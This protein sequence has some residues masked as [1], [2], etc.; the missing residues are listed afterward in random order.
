MVS[1]QSN[2]EMKGKTMGLLLPDR[3][4]FDEGVF[5][6]YQYDTMLRCELQG[7]LMLNSKSFEDGG[8]I[9]IPI[10]YK[11]I[12]SYRNGVA[13][14]INIAGNLIYIR[15]DGEKLY[16]Q[17]FPFIPELCEDFKKNGKAKVGCLLD[18]EIV[19]RGTMNRD[20]DLFLKDYS[21]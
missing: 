16:D 9:F 7:L 12:L 20:G 3:E 15:N 2:L 18:G 11:K 17:E 13:R 1:M 21:E 10:I 4:N 19:L 5:I 14:A 6:A 8:N